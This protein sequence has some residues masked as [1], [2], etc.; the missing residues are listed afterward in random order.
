MI[1]QEKLSCH[2]VNTSARVSNRKGN[3]LE[4]SEILQDSINTIFYVPQSSCNS[5]NEAIFQNLPHAIDLMGNKLKILCSHLDFNAMVIY[6]DYQVTDKILFAVEEK[7]IDRENFD[8]QSPC[9]INITNN[10]QIKS[11]FVIANDDIVF[12]NLYLKSLL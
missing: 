2:F 12:F 7:L 3:R 8:I 5:C 11:V 9:V 6:S 4:L 1:L 10:G